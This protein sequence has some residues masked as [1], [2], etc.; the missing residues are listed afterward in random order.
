MFRNK[1]LSL[2]PSRLGP[3]GGESQVSKSARP[4][5]KLRAGSGEPGTEKGAGSDPHPFLISSS[6]IAIS[7]YLHRQLLGLYFV[8]RC[9]ELRGK[10]RKRGVDRIC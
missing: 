4:F 7:T 9:S 10:S 5:D 1:D 8:C 6:I 3:S 2:D